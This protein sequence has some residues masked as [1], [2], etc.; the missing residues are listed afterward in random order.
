MTPGETGRVS[1]VHFPPG[2]DVPL[3]V[4]GRA[5]RQMLNGVLTGSMP[6]APRL[7]EGGGMLGEARESTVLTPKGKM[8]ASLRVVGGMGVAAQEGE[9][10]FLLLVPQAALEG[11]ARHFQRYLPPRMARVVPLHQDWV[12]L[13]LAG[14]DVCGRLAES[15]LF[16]PGLEGAELPGLTPAWGGTHP[17]LGDLVGVSSQG[18]SVPSWDL[19]VQEGSLPALHELL[20]RTGVEAAPAGLAEIFRVE[21]GSPEYGMELNP[22]TIPVEAGMQHRAIDH[23]KGCYTGQ[24]VIVRIRDRGR[25]NRHLRGL[26]LG[27]ETPP[28]S[29]TSLFQPDGTRPVGETATAV[30]SEVMGGTI[31]LGYVRREVEP[32]AVV[33]LGTPEGPPVQVREITD[34]GW[35]LLPDDAGYPGRSGLHGAGHSR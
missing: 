11:L 7:L 34:E 8:V 29:G 23:T 21:R 22:D 5:A 20:E 15:G 30:V 18:L 26:L 3:G 1:A 27:T 24:E 33:H 19:L 25:V 2:R 10:G 16:L 28:P 9:E 12:V 32:P 14:E 35:T 17:E 6:T 4:V 13:S 31:A